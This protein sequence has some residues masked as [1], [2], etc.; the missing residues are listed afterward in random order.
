MKEYYVL[1]NW[2]ADSA[3]VHEAGCKCCVD[4]TAATTGKWHRPFVNPM[5]AA[6]VAQTLGLGRAQSC[7]ECKA[8]MPGTAPATHEMAEHRAAR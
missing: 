6:R 3:Q 2:A 7:A 5:K 4:A 8:P 1:E